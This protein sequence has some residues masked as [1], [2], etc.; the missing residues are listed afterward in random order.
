[1]NA[2]QLHSLETIR[3][4]VDSTRSKFE[5]DKFV[6]RIENLRNIYKT[7]KIKT[8]FAFSSFSIHTPNRR[9]STDWNLIIF[10]FGVG[11][12]KP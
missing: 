1:M 10:F 4:T 8:I 2:M 12:I 6:G 7:T 5:I 9:I 3:L 11:R